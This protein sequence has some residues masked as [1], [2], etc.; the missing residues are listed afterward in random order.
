[1]WGIVERKQEKR[2]SEGWVNK[3]NEGIVSR[4]NSGR[5]GTGNEG[6]EVC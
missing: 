2:R 6:G 4:R 3:R 5:I 1:M